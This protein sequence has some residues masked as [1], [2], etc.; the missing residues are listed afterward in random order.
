MIASGS[1]TGNPFESVELVELARISC[2]MTHEE[3]G[4]RTGGRHG[5]DTEENTRGDGEEE[6]TDTASLMPLAAPEAY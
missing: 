4:V 3:E 1:F 6:G 5:H 2:T